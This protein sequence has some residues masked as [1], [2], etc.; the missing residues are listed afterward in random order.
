ME[1]I[2]VAHTVLLYYSLRLSESDNPFWHK[3]LSG[4]DH[5]QIE[6]LD[7]FIDLKKPLPKEYLLVD[8][9]TFDDCIRG[10]EAEF[11]N[12]NEWHR[13]LP[14]KKIESAMEFSIMILFSQLNQIYKF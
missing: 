2:E 14:D 13:R 11:G 9:E 10:I 7:K 3:P 4:F 1:T 6:R 8:C 5:E 12:L